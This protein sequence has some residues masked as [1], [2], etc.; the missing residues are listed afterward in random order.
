MERTRDGVIIV[1]IVRYIA[2]V[3]NIRTRTSMRLSTLNWSDQQTE[4][5]FYKAISLQ[6]LALIDVMFAGCE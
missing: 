1:Y 6:Y 5:E 4:L 2:K 3:C